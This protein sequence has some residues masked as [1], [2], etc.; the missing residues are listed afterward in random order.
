MA[1]ALLQCLSHSPLMG[2]NP[3]SHELD[4]ELQAALS[5]ARQAITD[6]APE[7]ALMFVPDHYNGFYYDLMPSFCVGMQAQAIGDYG[8]A[9][10]TLAVPERLAL[11]C[12]EHLLASGFDPAMS[13]DM[14]V[15]HGT[16]QPLTLLLGGLDRL[17]VL[18]IFINAAAAPLA[19]IARSFELGRAVGN[20]L[21]DHAARVLIMG[22]GGLSHDPPIPRMQGGDDAARRFLTQGRHLS[23]QARDEMRHR[24]VPAA[25]RFAAEGGQALGISDLNPAWDNAFL[26]LLEA[27]DF[28]SLTALSNEEIERDG[29]RAAHE[30]RNWIAAFGAM[31]S[32][33]AWRPEGRF[34]AP[35]PQWIAGFAMLRARMAEQVEP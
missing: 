34:Y 31:A 25:L 27:G 12:C 15:D 24:T 22:S 1:N 3:I 23:Q 2:L 13:Y 9:S 14:R 7:V 32:F 28:P 19:P 17:P 4:Q 16:A 29:G 35:I 18:P 8:T 26:D 30:V 5:T 33:G 10:G 11:Q 6:F 21:K 20:F